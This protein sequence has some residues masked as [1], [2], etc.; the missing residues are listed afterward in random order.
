MWKL[1]LWQLCQGLYLLTLQDL[2]SLVLQ[3]HLMILRKLATWCIIVASQFLMSSGCWCS[4]VDSATQTSSMQKS[5]ILTAITEVREES[6][7]GPLCWQSLKVK[8]QC[9]LCV[10]CRNP[11]PTCMTS[12]NTRDRV[13]P[14]WQSVSHL[15]KCFLSKNL[16]PIKVT[17]VPPDKVFPVSV[18]DKVVPKTFP[19]WQSQWF[20][21][22][23]LVPPDKSVSYLTKC[24]QSASYVTKCFLSDKAFPT[25]Q[26][27][28]SLTKC[29]SPQY[30][31]KCFLSQYPTKYFLSAW[32]ASCSDSDFSCMLWRSTVDRNEHIWLAD[33]LSKLTL[34]RSCTSSRKSLARKG[35]NT[36]QRWPVWNF[37]HLLWV[38][39]FLV[40]ANQQ[41]CQGA[42]KN[43][44]QLR[45]FLSSWPWPEEGHTTGDEP[46]LHRHNCDQREYEDSQYPLQLPS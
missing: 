32:K 22:N 2:A 24:F 4:H 31:T 12:N 25:W 36:T 7:S 19:I 26:D 6:W 43:H 5:H 16:F 35:L 3:S 38:S 45:D 18:S 41:V 44:P 42:E 10:R 30:L 20:L 21:S 40:S 23:K 15:T 27:V 13:F 37:S 9:L 11:F 34:W 14:T 1:S 33:S 29:Y 28:S 46:W 8:E 39:M 17:V